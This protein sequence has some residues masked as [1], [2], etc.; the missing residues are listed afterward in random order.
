V[1]LR[2]KFKKVSSQEYIE[3][4]HGDTELFSSKKGVPAG[5]KEAF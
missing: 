4:G 1:L 3:I 5:Q 2:D